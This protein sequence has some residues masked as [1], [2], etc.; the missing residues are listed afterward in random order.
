MSRLLTAA[1]AVPL[2]L[3]I[4]LLGPDWLFFA[5]ALVA[6]LLGY[7]ELAA[8]IKSKMKSSGP[9]LLGTG[10]LTV[11]LVTSAFYLEPLTLT[12]ATLASILVIAGSV[13]FQWSP[14]KERLVGVMGTFFATFYV[15]ALMGS[16]VALRMLGP[17]PAGRHWVI[18]LLA[19]VFVGD[20]GAYYTGRSLGRH[21]LAPRL[22]PKKTVEGLVGGLV[23]SIAAAV[24]LA[25][26]WFPELETATA[27]GLGSM[28]GLMGVI[29]DL[30]ES[31]L[32]RSAG[33]KDTSALIP[34]HGG[35]LDR[36]DSVLFA[37]PALLLC[38]LWMA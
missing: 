15:G 22:S 8:L 30:F 11:L 12:H 21:A 20:A 7:W 5:L 14:D 28:L 2:L 34:G 37:G 32:K 23:A 27:I 36:I 3:A 1:V 38:L 18:F 31:F 33:V 24:A 6:A 17:E 9:A 19:V 13:V 10:Y 35:V 29:G 25:E 26:L 16:I 4:I